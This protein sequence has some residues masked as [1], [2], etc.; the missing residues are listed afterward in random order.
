MNLIMLSC[1][2]ATFL[3]EKSHDKP[4]SFIDKLQLS[5]H[6]KIC[7][8]CSGYQKQSLLI[9]MVLKVNHKKFSNPSNFKLSD[10][11][12]T[13]IQKAVEENSKNN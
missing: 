5:M 1:R 7:D 8:K 3:I 12:K 13:R 4:L 2:K 11:S 6:L 9:E 10:S